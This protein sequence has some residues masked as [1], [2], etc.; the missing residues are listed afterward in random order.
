[1]RLAE[2]SFSASFLPPIEKRRLLDD[3]RAA[4]KS[5]GLV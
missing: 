2:E 4:A 5:A 1:L 3:F